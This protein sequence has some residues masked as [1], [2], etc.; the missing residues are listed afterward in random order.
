MSTLNKSDNS[1]SS[2][3]C[4][5]A[6]TE[7]DKAT[8]KLLDVPVIISNVKPISIPKHL[9]VMFYI[10]SGLFILSEVIFV[11]CLGYFLINLFFKP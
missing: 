8:N 6:S 5:K 2:T 1:T 11:Y 4:D 7:C 10:F 9:I 3:E